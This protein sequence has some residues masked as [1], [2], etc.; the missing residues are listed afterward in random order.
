MR[1]WLAWKGKEFEEYDIEADAA[2]RERIRALA[3]P[4]YNVPVL[5]ED[6]KVIQV[7]WQG[8]RCVVNV[9]S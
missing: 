6:G 9:A 2:A 1:E 5:V 7:G 3:Q 8:R 4:P